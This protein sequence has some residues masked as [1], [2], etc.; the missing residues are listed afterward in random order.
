[1]TDKRPRSLDEPECEWCDGTGEW[2]VEYPD[3]ATDA[4]GGQSFHVERCPCEKCK[5]SG[6]ARF[7]PEDLSARTRGEK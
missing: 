2:E 4:T 6:V 7:D 3:R 5:G 1:M